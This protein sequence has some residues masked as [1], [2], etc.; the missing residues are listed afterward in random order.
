[1]PDLRL[2]LADAYSHTGA[3]K[4]AVDHLLTAARLHAEQEEYEMTVVAYRKALEIQSRSPE[5]MQKLFDA[6][7]KA[8]K[9]VQAQVLGLELG[10]LLREALQFSKA[11]EVYQKL[12]ERDPK[13]T[14]V[15]MLLA[16][17][18]KG[19]GDH[20]KALVEYNRVAD[21]LENEMRFTELEKVYR[22]LK[23]L[24][25]KDDDLIK[26]RRKYERIEQRREVRERRRKLL[27]YGTI[28]FVFL[29]LVAAGW[30]FWSSHE[31]QKISWPKVY[32]LFVLQGMSMDQ[33]YRSVEKDPEDKDRFG[34]YIKK[35]EEWIGPEGDCPKTLVQL[36]E[37]RAKHIVTLKMFQARTAAANI[38]DLQEKIK[39]RQSTLLRQY[40]EH[41]QA[42]IEAGARKKLTKAE[43]LVSAGE[44][45]EAWKI[46]WGV[47]TDLDLATV[48]KDMMLPILVSSDPEGA[49]VYVDGVLVGTA[50]NDRPLFFKPTES[51]RTIL[52]R[53]ERRGYE[54]V[55]KEP[56][57]LQLFQRI[58]NVPMKRKV[59]STVSV[60]GAV[61]GVPLDFEGQLV[62]CARGGSIP[63]DSAAMIYRLAEGMQV[64][65]P[66][67]LAEAGGKITTPLIHQGALFAGTS[68]GKL[69]R[70]TPYAPLRLL[71][72]VQ[73]DE[74]DVGIPITA[75]PAALAEGKWIYFAT[76]DGRV[77]RFDPTIQNAKPQVIFRA[78]GQITSLQCLPAP[79][80]DSDNPWVIIGSLDEKVRVLLGRTGEV[81]WQFL[82]HGDVFAPPV[83]TR[84]H[85][86]VGTSQGA[87]FILDRMTGKQLKAVH[88]YGPVLS[89]AGTDEIAYI[90]GIKGGS[91]VT[92]LSVPSCDKLW[93][94]ATAGPVDSGI[95]LH[96]GKILFGD[97]SGRLSVLDARTGEFR[98]DYVAG[99]PITAKPLCARGRV[100][101]G[102]DTGQI[103]IINL[104]IDDDEQE[105]SPR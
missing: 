4:A 96:E 24:A 72:V 65:L 25:T 90:G 46:Y 13:E 73:S 103:A 51:A 26:I 23:A 49:D 70:I 69:Y 86:Y 94:W 60:D 100:Y 47:W 52:V 40:G 33:I 30:E 37:F 36:E 34:D 11:V 45:D 54:T 53:L 76:Y 12:A 56:L 75:G 67:N 105:E 16:G 17:A 14:S 2:Q 48:R 21:Q 18:Y 32:Q 31:Y 99:A 71:A 85:V 59:R 101:V 98:W 66:A 43:E 97:H 6:L 79:D 28:L 35:Y 102:D 63:G 92:A 22:I 20:E 50:T 89:L 61:H 95:R 84:S 91:G 8:D 57:P 83:V 41:N 81:V 68:E 104:S 42:F 87:F 1:N 64:E 93:A 58:V 55:T 3:E 10:E 78:E 74:T 39:D 27:S 29:G 62:I 80:G 19:K 9:L 7:I 77:F 38:R 82:A 5:I 15:R 88:G 44:Y